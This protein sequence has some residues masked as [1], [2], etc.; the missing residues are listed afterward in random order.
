MKALLFLISF[1]LI[2]CQENP[3]GKSPRINPG[4]LPGL[5]IPP[6]IDSISPNRGPNIGGTN[7]TIYGKGMT[8]KTRIFIDSIPCSAIT[9][10]SYQRMICL[11][12][13]GTVGVKDVMVLNVDGQKT[14][15]RDLFTYVPNIPATPGYTISAGGKVSQSANLTLKATISEPTKQGTLRGSTLQLK[16][17]AQGI[18]IVE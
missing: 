1:L 6:Q 13:V 4:F 15:A 14:V 9:F 2:S 10:V 5:G 18:Q 11:T 8:N 16:G 3:L 17:G 7:I 12:P